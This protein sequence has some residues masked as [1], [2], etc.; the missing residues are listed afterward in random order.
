MMYLCL[1]FLT[2]WLTFQA[3]PREG[4]FGKMCTRLTH[5][6]SDDEMRDLDSHD[7]LFQAFGMTKS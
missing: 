2:D 1:L 4:M 3:V 5:A 7:F 6:M